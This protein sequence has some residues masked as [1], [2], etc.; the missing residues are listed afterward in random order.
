MKNRPII[1][2]LAG[3][4]GIALAVY[5]MT[6][7]YPFLVFEVGIILQIISI[8]LYAKTKNRSKFI[9][10]FCLLPIVGL[11]IGFCLIYFNAFV[12]KKAAGSTVTPI[13]PIIENNPSTTIKSTSP[14]ITR[15][16][17]ASTPSDQICTEM[18]NK[19]E[20]NYPIP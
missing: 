3:I 4:A 9:G 5:A 1:I 19:H 18:I 8:G 16:D 7:E 10:L 13:E 11:F 14:P 15:E 6:R 17:A 20:S 2:L 12:K